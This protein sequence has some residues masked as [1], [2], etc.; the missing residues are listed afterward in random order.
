MIFDCGPTIQERH[1]AKRIWHRWFAWH[2]IRLAAHKC[3]W[4]QFI[5][6]RGNEKCSWDEWWWEWE[7]R[8]I[9]ND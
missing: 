3:A 1:A 2:P 6:R 5:E 8:E 9:T 4:L 7:Y